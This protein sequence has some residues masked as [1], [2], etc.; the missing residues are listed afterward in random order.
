M[1]NVENRQFYLSVGSLVE[2][3]RILRPSMLVWLS[4]IGYLPSHRLY[5][6]ARGSFIKD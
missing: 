5:F 2:T 6:V 3:P 1:R 4:I